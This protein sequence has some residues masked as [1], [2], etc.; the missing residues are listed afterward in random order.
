VHLN[1]SSSLLA[2]P[3]VLNN[4]SSQQH[5]LIQLPLPF[6]LLEL[7]CI[8]TQKLLHLA[9]KRIKSLQRLNFSLRRQFNR[10]FAVRKAVLGLTFDIE[11]L[12]SL[13][14]C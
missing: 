6:R 3:I 2:V 11:S 9:S 14:Y 8:L 5:C 13:D 10:L 4:S 7:I 1:P 12:V